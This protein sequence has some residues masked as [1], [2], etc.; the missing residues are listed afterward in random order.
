MSTAR[1]EPPSARQVPTLTC[2]GCVVEPVA[3]TSAV[4]AK[5]GEVCW[6]SSASAPVLMIASRVAVETAGS[7]VGA[8]T[9]EKPVTPVHRP[10]ASPTAWVLE[11][12]DEPVEVPEVCAER[13]PVAPDA[14]GVDWTGAVAV[15]PGDVDPEADGA[16]DTGC[17][18]GVV[19][20]ALPVFD[21]E[22]VPLEWVDD[23]VEPAVGDEAV[24]VDGLGTR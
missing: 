5:E 10:E 18:D 21:G 3:F 14:D 23:V 4:P 9:P 22:V 15:A 20:A 19:V 6:G 13:V 2:T 12:V 11:P 1:I 17:V 16:L 24:E 8:L 7:V